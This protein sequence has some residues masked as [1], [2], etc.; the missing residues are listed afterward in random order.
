MDFRAVIFDLDGTILD[1][2]GDLHAAMNEALRKNGYPMHDLLFIKN[3]IGSGVR[4]LTRRSLPQD[5]RQDEETV[6]FVCAQMKEY[7]LEHWNV[8]THPY[9][10]IH[11]LLRFLTGIGVSVNVL[12]NKADSA[13]QKM[14]PYWY[15]DIT[16]DY[17]F[18]ERKGIPTKPDPTSAKE[19]SA[20]LGIAPE[21]ILFV[22]D[23]A[24]DILAAKGA[25]MHSAGVLWGYRSKAVLQDAGAE[26]LAESPKDI[27][28]LFS[29]SK[30]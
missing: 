7:Y 5:L 22:G 20:L 9:E 19:L 27:A 30:P 6:D 21:H 28:D 17:I 26:F 18:G 14:V 25:G 29:E 3:A 4:E 8:T 10:G 2:L 1:T 23:S 24:A 15:S 13:T 11:E 12:S 16:F